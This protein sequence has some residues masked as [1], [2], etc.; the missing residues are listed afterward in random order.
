MKY[1]E[2]NYPIVVLDRNL[3]H[4]NI[5][6][7]LLSNASGSKEAMHSFKNDKVDKVFIISG[8]KYNFDSH[9][10]LEAAVE[11]AEAEGMDYEV[12]Q[13]D[14]NAISGYKAAK[15]AK[16][17][18]DE[19]V[20]IFALNDEMALGAYNYFKEVDAPLGEQIVVKGFDHS[21]VTKHLSPPIESVEYSKSDW[22]AIGVETL[23]KMIQDEP[24]ENAV[25]P[26]FFHK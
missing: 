12:L 18:A 17:E 3:Q 19:R 16:W 23:F 21:E 24:V 14:F 9:E 5:R 4:K 22:G 6:T 7:V 8:P 1:A 15:R 20:G 25:I 2:L 11:V 10:R 26:T 13:G